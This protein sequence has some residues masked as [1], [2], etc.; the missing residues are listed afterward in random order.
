LRGIHALLN[1]VPAMS[2]KSAIDVELIFDLNLQDRLRRW[3]F[4]QLPEAL[5]V[6]DAAAGPFGGRLAA[7]ERRPKRSDSMIPTRFPNRREFMKVSAASAIATAAASPSHLLAQS[8]AKADCTLR[9][10]QTKVELAPNHIVST[11]VYNDQF[12]GP[13]LR[14][15]EG[16]RVIVDI[17]NDTDT[18]ELVHWHGQMIPSD[19]DGAA[20]EGTPFVPAHGMRRIELVPRPSGFRFYHTHVAAGGDLNRGTYTGQVAPLYIEAANNPGTYDR[21]AG[22]LAGEIKDQRL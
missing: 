10:R 19:I 2:Q 18:P 22:R 12:P 21:E 20:E 7:R 1:T 13:L 8:D 16:R 4:D 3:L 9:I 14:L 5:T 17:H 15:K 6:E 11:T